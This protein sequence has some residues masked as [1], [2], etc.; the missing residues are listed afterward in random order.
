MSIEMQSFTGKERDAET[1]LDYFAGFG[2]ALGVG[3]PHGT[4]NA[5]QTEIAAEKKSPE[6]A[7]GGRLKDRMG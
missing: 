2:R 7:S 4:M 6:A 3:V 1:G 5:A